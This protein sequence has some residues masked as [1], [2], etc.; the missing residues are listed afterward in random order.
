ML[1]DICVRIWSHIFKSQ[2]CDLFINKAWP[3]FQIHTSKVIS[4]PLYEI[5]EDLCIESYWT[6]TGDSAKEFDI[7]ICMLACVVCVEWVCTSCT[8]PFTPKRKCVVLQDTSHGGQPLLHSWL[9]AS[10]MVLQ[11]TFDKFKVILET[12]EVLANG[13]HVRWEGRGARVLF[14]PGS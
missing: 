4:K 7:V 5:Q 9:K 8:Y 6:L 12:G 11:Q 13:R 10:G 1:E 2:K 3:F 14:I